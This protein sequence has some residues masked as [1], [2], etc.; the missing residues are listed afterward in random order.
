MNERSDAELMTGVAAGDES[1]LAEIY[2]RHGDA[3]FRLSY[4]LL[5]D[6]GLAEEVLQETMLAVWDKAERYD[7]GI[8]SLAA[9]LMTIARNRSIDRLRSRARRPTPLTL[10]ALGGADE[11]RGPTLDS[12]IESGQLVAAA[13]APLDPEV[14]ADAAWLREALRAALDGLP[15][16][17]RKAL[18]LAY[19]EE[20]TQVEIADRLGWPL[21]TVKT[22]TRRA[23][24]RLRGVL[25]DALGP[26]LGASI[27][28]PADAPEAASR[29]V[30]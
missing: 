30:R 29:D 18:E 24:F 21:G 16:P 14:L 23:L 26:E 11:E 19:Y 10:G 15:L 12:A 27:R 3:A 13:A 9:W 7:P 22:R 1:A 17:E 20:L 5:G 25:A 8:A 2:D 4:R 6:R 28:P